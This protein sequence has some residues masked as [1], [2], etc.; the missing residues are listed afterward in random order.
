MM[1]QDGL[2]VSSEAGGT[3]ITLNRPLAPGAAAAWPAV[4]AIDAA[5]TGCQLWAS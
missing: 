1:A 4:A 2:T 3:I 5:N